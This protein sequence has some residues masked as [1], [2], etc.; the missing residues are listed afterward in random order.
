MLYGKS[1]ACPPTDTLHSALP[2]PLDYA[3]CL[4]FCEASSDSKDFLASCIHIS[5]FVLGTCELV[6]LSPA[7][8]R[9]SIIAPL[10]SEHG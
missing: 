3:L 7:Y 10:P 6:C 1:V 5:I 2:W 9:V 8:T 4:L